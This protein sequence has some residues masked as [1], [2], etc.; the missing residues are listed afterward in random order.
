MTNVVV[1]TVEKVDPIGV[2]V[3]AVDKHVVTVGVLFELAPGL[4]LGLEPVL[5]PVDIVVTVP[6]DVVILVVVTVVVFF[7][8]QHGV[9]IPQL[10]LLH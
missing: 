4:V 6:V 5:E 10:Q 7:V 2:A 8:I 3:V 1:P 9:V